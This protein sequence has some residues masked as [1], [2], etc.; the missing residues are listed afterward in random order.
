MSLNFVSTTVL[1]STDGVSHNTE[2]RNENADN[3]ISSSINRSGGGG[4]EFKPLYEQLR[5][6]AQEDQDKYDEMTKAMRGTRTL[7]DED[8]AHLQGIENQRSKRLHSQAMKEQEE[9]ES[10]RLAKLDHEDTQQS[11]SNKMKQQKEM[12]EQEINELVN[13]TKIYF[14]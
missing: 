8:V 3:T 7:D 5:Q 9:L 12:E 2:T 14:A 1:S 4:G 6:N 10:Y 11:Q 13:L